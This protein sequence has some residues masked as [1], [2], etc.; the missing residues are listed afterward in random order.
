MLVS[1]KTVSILK[2][3]HGINQSLFLRKGKKQST[4]SLD[5]DIYAEAILEDDITSELG[6]YDLQRFLGNLNILSEPSIEVE[7][8][9]IKLSDKNTTITYFACSRDLINVPDDDLTFD[10]ENVNVEFSLSSTLLS[11]ALK[12]ASINGSDRIV[13]ERKDNKLNINTLNSKENT[14]NKARIFVCDNEGD[15]MKSTFSVETINKIMDIDYN[16]RI[17]SEDLGIAE[18]SSKDETIRYYISQME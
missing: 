1:N 9:A 5:E 11:K 7:D 13:F 16:V 17:N 14:A 3:F 8:K 12:L 4:I 2:N 18:F 10:L 15:D 6:I